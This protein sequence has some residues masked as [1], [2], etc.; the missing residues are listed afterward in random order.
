MELTPT[1][2]Q[3]LTVK[4]APERM[5]KSGEA[6]QRGEVCQ[7]G[8]QEVS[9]SAFASAEVAFLP[10]SGQFPRGTPKLDSQLVS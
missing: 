4:Y 10:L 5:L 8:R 9:H 1:S 2:T 3:P 7:F 6:L